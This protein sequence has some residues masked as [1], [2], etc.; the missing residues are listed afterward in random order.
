MS[1]VS[2]QGYQIENNPVNNNPFWEYEVEAEGIKSIQCTKTT[3]GDFDYYNWSYTDKDDVSHHILTQ[4]VSNKAG[5]DGTTFSPYY[6]A[7]GNLCWTNDGGKPVPA[8]FHIVG[9]KGDKGDPGIQGPKGDPGERGLQGVQGP[10]GIPGVPGQ[11]GLDGLPP[12]VEVTNIT[13]G[14]RITFTSGGVSTYADIMN[15]QDGEDGSNGAAATVNVGTVSTGAPG[16]NASV[17]N[18]GTQSAAVL[19]F[20]IPAGLTG[21]TG[22]D[23]QDGADGVSPE[24]SIETVAGGHTV[25]ITDADH[26]T[27]QTFTVADGQDGMGTIEVGSTTTGEP[28]TQASVSNSGSLQNAVLNFTI[29]QG[30]PGPQGPAGQPGSGTI[31]VGTTTTG[32]PGTNASVVNSGTIQNAILDF[33]IPTGAQGPAGPKGDPGIGTVTVGTTA[34][35]APGTSAAVTNSG[36]SQDAILNFTIPQGVQGPAG[37]DGADGVGVPAGGTSGQVLAKASGTDYDTEWAT[38]G[39]VPTGGTTGQLLAKLSG[40]NYDTEWVNPE[41]PAYTSSDVGKV[42]AVNNNY[43]GVE[44]KSMAA[45]GG[46]PFTPSGLKYTV[47]TGTGSI[48]TYSVS[49]P[50]DKGGK[51]TGIR[52]ITSIP[53]SAIEGH[54][55]TT[56]QFSIGEDQIIPLA[57]TEDDG[58]YVTYEGASVLACSDINGRTAPT[59]NCGVMFVARKRYAKSVSLTISL[60][61]VTG[62]YSTGNTPEY[63]GSL[64]TPKAAV[65]E[66]ITNALELLI[67]E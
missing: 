15:G 24:V 62:I 10:Q 6:D 23:G 43:N 14:K 49:I 2:P 11:D 36:T 31:D 13:G 42:L 22:A 33:T 46:H 50:A 66:D 56:V 1:T 29:P 35:G 63:L 58:D 45:G 9:A 16:T 25:T 41:L 34:T 5:T 18:S 51:I 7:S 61:G 20:V 64:K 44:W 67:Y 8:P 12:V 21:A 65:T 53:V 48:Q 3:V 40:S 37:E 4:E 30:L 26:P 19:D 38:I 27:G 59:I 32:L 54:N 17:T 47:K 55:G 60:R 28:G 39:K 52:L 57:K